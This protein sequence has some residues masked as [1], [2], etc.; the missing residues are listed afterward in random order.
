[1]K[2]I[3]FSLFFV[4]GFLIPCGVIAADFNCGPGYI[5]VSHNDIDDIEAAECQKLWCRDLETDKA[6]GSWDRANTR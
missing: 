6:M 5:L 3:L 4:C 1:M 2:R